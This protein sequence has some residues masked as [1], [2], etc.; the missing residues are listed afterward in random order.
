MERKA[1]I[2]IAALVTVVLLYAA[3][4]YVRSSPAK[5][6]ETRKKTCISICSRFAQSKASGPCLA[7]AGQNGMTDGWVCDVA[8]NPRQPVDDLKENQCATFGPGKHFV[9]V[10]PDCILIRAV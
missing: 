8:H 10:D 5:M 9:E 4:S 1:A 2:L 6:A 3:Y 7:E